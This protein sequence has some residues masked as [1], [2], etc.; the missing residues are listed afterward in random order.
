M[1]KLR[2]AAGFPLSDEMYY[3]HLATR[4]GVVLEV[5]PCLLSCFLDNVQGLSF[6]LVS[7]YGLV[8]AFT[9]GIF[10]FEGAILKKVLKMC[11]KH[12]EGNIVIFMCTAGST[13]EF[14]SRLFRAKISG[15]GS[16]ALQPERYGAM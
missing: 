10:D 9:C 5:F 1:E 16:L 2:R 8:Q 6:Y 13:N 12:D 14:I 11:E 15:T 3:V 7:K 4:R